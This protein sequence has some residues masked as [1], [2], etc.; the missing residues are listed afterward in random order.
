MVQVPLTFFAETLSGIFCS[1][2][3]FKNFPR[4][5]PLQ[6]FMRNPE[7]MR[8]QWPALDILA[9]FTAVFS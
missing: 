5:A 9:T 8:A 7:T 3:N 2:S 4:S 1:E 6:A